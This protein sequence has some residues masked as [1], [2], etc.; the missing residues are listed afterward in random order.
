MSQSVKLWQIQTA[1]R[2]AGRES[3]SDPRVRSLLARVSH[4]M[5]ESQPEHAIEVTNEEYDFIQRK[6]DSILNG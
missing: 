2:N 5:L 1:V 4:D 3:L 6:A